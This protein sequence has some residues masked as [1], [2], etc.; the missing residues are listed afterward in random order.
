MRVKY[1]ADTV[2]GREFNM[3][4]REGECVTYPMFDSD[5]VP[6]ET[7]GVIFDGDEQVTYVLASSIT[8]I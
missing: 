1:T 6:D 7:I 3:I 2:W 5:Y 8:E 4:G